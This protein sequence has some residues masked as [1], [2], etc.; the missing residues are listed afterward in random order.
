MGNIKNVFLY[1]DGA[2]IVAG[3]EN[4]MLFG[5]YVVNRADMLLELSRLEKDREDAYKIRKVRD[6]VYLQGR[7]LN[8]VSHGKTL[9]LDE[10][11]TRYLIGRN[12]EFDKAVHS[13][14][15][16]PLPVKELA[17]V[18]ELRGYGPPS[19]RGVAI[20]AVTPNG[21]HWLAMVLSVEAAL[22]IIGSIGIDPKPYVQQL[23]EE[24]GRGL[25]RHAPN[26]EPICFF[27]ELPFV[28]NHAAHHR[29]KLTLN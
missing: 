12:S 2:L 25:S 7:G 29:A 22:T 21:E 9:D 24:E 3:N 10:H 8:R 14:S 27:G 5:R 23:R 11:E 13:S 15:F 28:I 6:S 19:N 26:A 16:T 18:V 20:G 1:N 4:E 17:Y